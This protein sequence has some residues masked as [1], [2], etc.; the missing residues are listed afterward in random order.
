MEHRFAEK[1]ATDSHS[2]KSTG[3]FFFA[4]GFN[5]VRMSQLVQPLVALDDLAT[6]PSVLPFGACS[7]DFTEVI[8]DLD[9]ENFFSGDTPQRVRH[10]K[11]F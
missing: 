11:I 6:D 5:R 8:V 7:D 9:L 10:M 4:P 2:V 1:S 3:E